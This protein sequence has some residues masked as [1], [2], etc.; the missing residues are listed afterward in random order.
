M[1][2]SKVDSHSKHYELIEL[3]NGIYAGI[4]K[5]GGGG[6]GN[7]GI[8]DLGNHTV[9]FDTFNTQQAAQDL[10]IDAERLTGKPVTYVINSHW[11]GDHIRGNQVFTEASIISTTK[12][13][14][15]MKKIHPQRIEQQKSD[16]AGLDK[17]IYSLESDLNKANNEDQ[18][19]DLTHQ[20]SFLH[21]LRDSLP[22]LELVLPNITFETKMTIKGS[23][24]EIKL[25]TYGG[26]HTECDMCLFLEKEKIAFVGDLATNRHHP[27]LLDGDPYNWR[28][29]NS[30]LME[31]NLDLVVPGHGFVGA[32]EIISSIDDYLKGILS[33]TN[34]LEKECFESVKVPEA[35]QSWESQN[36]FH[37]NLQYIS[38]L[39]KDR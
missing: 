22:K 14:S 3:T 25:V 33:M 7:S 21:E 8:I 5:D 12:T 20:I 31:Q 26:G 24:R 30:K 27:R 35:F 6:V 37:K 19:N 28:K 2:L 16:L 17:Y 15:L 23:K 34:N 29:I 10:K 9:I 13:Y 36:L 11:H 39:Q 1:N 38:E 18:N 32:M 4:V